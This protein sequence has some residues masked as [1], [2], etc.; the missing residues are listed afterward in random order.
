[1]NLPFKA[2]IMPPLQCIEMIDNDGHYNQDNTSQTEKH[3]TY[4]EQA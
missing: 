3:G 1:L 4:Q 2:E